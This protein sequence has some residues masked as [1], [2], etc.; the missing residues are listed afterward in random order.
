[1]LA[2]SSIAAITSSL[3]TIRCSTPG[4]VALI[5]YLFIKNEKARPLAGQ[6]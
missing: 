1:M 6:T 3:S 5:A 4:C 2:D